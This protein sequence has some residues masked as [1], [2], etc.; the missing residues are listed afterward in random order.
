MIVTIGVYRV[1]QGTNFDHFGPEKGM[2]CAFCS[3]I[4]IGY[5]F[6]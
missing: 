5:G 3:G 4:N 6:Y 2:V 1:K